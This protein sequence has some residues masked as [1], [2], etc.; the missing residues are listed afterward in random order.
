MEKRPLGNTD[1]QVSKICLGTMT[2]GE[3]NT[4]DEAFMQMDYALEHGVNFFDTAE[5][6]AIP[7]T[8]QSYGKTETIVGEWFAQSGKRSD[9]VLATKM[10]G[11][12]PD[13]IRGGAGFCVDDINTAIEGSLKRLQTDTIDLYQLHWPQ[14]SVAL[15]GRLNYLNKTFDVQAQDNLYNFYKALADACQSG[16]IRSIGLSN[17]TPWGVMKYQQL[18][19]QFKLPMMVSIQNAYSLLR[20]EFEVGLAEIALA[21]SVGLL[22]YSPLAGGVLSG[23]YRNGAMPEGSR[24]KLFPT[25]MGYYDNPRSLSALEAYSKLAEERE[26][27]LTQMSL[28]FVNDRAFMTSNIIGA[29]TMEQLSEN[30]A[31]ADMV[32]D[33]STLGAID[34][35]FKLYPNPGCY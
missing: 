26:M 13:W 30:I 22:A 27:T 9:V 7:P 20:R 31:S 4:R 15:W 35:L 23:K 17:E 8:P 21:E 29:T 14:R 16:K 6:Y 25:L 2:W 34:D 12:G 18:A 32:L 1:I 10:A 5:I 19:A 3:Q 11:P 33:D 28:A 24:F